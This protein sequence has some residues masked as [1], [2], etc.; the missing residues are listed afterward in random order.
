MKQKITDI[1]VA[2]ELPSHRQL[3]LNGAPFVVIHASL[4]EKFGLRIGL[5]IAAEVIEKIITADEVM[6]AKNHALRLLREE[7]D[8]AT[9]DEPEDS[10]PYSKIENVY[11]KRNSAA[12]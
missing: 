6:R 10:S 11:Q 8:N 12:A 1:Q 3:F 5:E 9:T 2:S 7:K 4:I